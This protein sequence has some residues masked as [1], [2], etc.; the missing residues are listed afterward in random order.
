MWKRLIGEC[1]DREQGIRELERGLSD[2]YFDALDCGALQ[3]QDA[4]AEQIN[5]APESNT[6]R[7]PDAPDLDTGLDNLLNEVD[8]LITETTK[9][10]QID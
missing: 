7:L 6:A 10:A 8:K 2:E 4:A 5:P 1:D 9:G 3:D